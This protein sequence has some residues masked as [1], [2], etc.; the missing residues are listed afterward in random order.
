MYVMLVLYI[1]RKIA[2]S[3]LAV[4][5]TGAHHNGIWLDFL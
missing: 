5:N 1:S 3:Y 4:E 2:C